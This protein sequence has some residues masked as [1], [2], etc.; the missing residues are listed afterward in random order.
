M[1]PTDGPFGIET[2]VCADPS[3]A[4]RYG[5]IMTVA[6][7]ILSPLLALCAAAAG[8]VHG[9]RGVVGLA[10]ATLVLGMAYAFGM[11]AL[12]RL[13]S[14]RVAYVVDDRGLS[15]SRRGKVV[16]EIDRDRISSF[17]MV[18]KM[19][20]RECVLVGQAPP[21]SWPQGQVGIIKRDDSRWGFP[22]KLLPEIMIWGSAEVRAAEWKIQQALRATGPLDY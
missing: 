14:A 21:P 8:A 1:V 3:Q 7:A 22:N 15:V 17:Y 16:V 2:V 9:V 6:F 5:R 13:R 20:L 4:W 19:D 10:F 18:G 12:W 11:G